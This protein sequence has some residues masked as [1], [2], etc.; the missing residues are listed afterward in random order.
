MSNMATTAQLYTR[1]A[2]LR[3]RVLFQHVLH[4]AVLEVLAA[5][6]LLLVGIGLLNFAIYLALRQP[7]GD[8][9]A[10][11]VVAALHFA[12]GG[13]ALAFALRDPVSS[14]L[15]ALSE[16]E[17]AAFDALSQDA[18]GIVNSVTTIGDRLQQFCTE[19]SLAMGAVAGLRKS[20]IRA[21]AKAEMGPP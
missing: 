3:R 9:G 16:A 15:E 14:E 2:L 5:L 6:L 13:V 4:R 10:V 11:L 8:I 18:S 1:V 20:M 12:I 7:L 17:A 19:A 21:N